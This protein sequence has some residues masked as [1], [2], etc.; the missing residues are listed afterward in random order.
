[1]TKAEKEAILALVR[2]LVAMA[3]AL[4]EALPHDWTNARQVRDAATLLENTLECEN[5]TK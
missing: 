3:E 1:M 2:E 5:L 4:D